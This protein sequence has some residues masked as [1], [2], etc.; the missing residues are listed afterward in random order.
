MPGRLC[1]Y[2]TNCP[3]TT[4][5][6]S[7]VVR[8][9]V[10]RLDTV[11]FAVPKLTIAR[12][13][14]GVVP[15]GVMYGKRKVCPAWIDGDFEARTVPLPA[16]MDTLALTAWPEIFVTASV[17]VGSGTSCTAGRYCVSIRV[18]ALSRTT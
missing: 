9:N 3:G 6:T 8:S 17:A 7:P 11:A 2:C 18:K 14:V 12:I 13:V 1:D 16:T 10:M 15:A 4:A 5:I